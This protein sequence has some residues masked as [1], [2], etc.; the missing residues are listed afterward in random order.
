MAVFPQ[1]RRGQ[2]MVVL[3][4]LAVAAL[5][6]VW[7]GTPIGG[8][9]GVSQLAKTRDSLQRQVDS[10]DAIV[11]SAKRTV[12]N[13]AVAQLERRLAEYRASLDMMRQ[14]VPAGE[15][16]PN[17]FDDI[18]SRAKVRGANVVNIVPAN[19]ESG[20]PFD[21]KRARVQVT[22]RYDQIG[23]YLS[24]IAGLPRIIV[25]YDVHLERINSPTADTSLT[26]RGILVATFQIRTYVKPVAPEPRRPAPGA[27]AAAAAPGAHR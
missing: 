22:G 19:L 4:I 12:A 26:R 1:D 25:P 9:S 10:L 16:M 5:Y 27:P 18:T 24:D 7:A 23:E 21:T 14:L 17:L 11:E 13:G 3:V 8:I 15:E 2:I 6:F 20:A